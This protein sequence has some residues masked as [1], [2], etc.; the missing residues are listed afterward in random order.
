MSEQS[1]GSRVEAMYDQQ[2]TNYADFKE[3][4]FS[5][6]FI[7]LPAFDRYLGGKELPHLANLYTPTT[8]VLDLGCGAGLVAQHLVSRGIDPKNITGIDLS[9][10]LVR[11]A[12][13]RV[14]GARFIHAS[15]DNFD[16]P[17]GSFDLVT[18]NMVFHYLNNEQLSRSLHLVYEALK[19][20]GTLF[21]IDADPDYNEATR[22][23]EN[24][25][26][27]LELPTPWGTTAPWFSRDPHELLLDIT[28]FAGFDVVGGFPLRVAD[29]GKVMPVEYQK[30]T[31]YPARMAARL[32]K[33]SESEKLSR[34]SSRNYSLPSLSN[35]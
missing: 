26:K 32:V 29:A 10:N 24:V 20:G 7:E 34:L 30:Y 28:H 1:Q 19:P 13:T 23:P 21:F 3:G 14:P 35:K 6:Q 11:E 17:A 15:I 27:W 25:N 9:Q 8:R 16:V 22:R 33:V 18:S 2:A 4:S 12:Q 31:N 5:W